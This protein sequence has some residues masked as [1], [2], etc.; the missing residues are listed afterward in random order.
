MF[1]VKAGRDGS[2]G[3]DQGSEIRDQDQGSRDP[4]SG[5][6]DPGSGLGRVRPSTETLD[7]TNQ[8]LLFKK[9]HFLIV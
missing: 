8:R 1:D 4:G 3:L 5:I 6:Q 9:H 7:A 2:E